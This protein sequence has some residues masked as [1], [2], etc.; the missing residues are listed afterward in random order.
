MPVICP[1]CN[2]DISCVSCND[3][4]CPNCGED[5]PRSIVM[6]QAMACS[7]RAPQEQKA[8]DRPPLKPIMVIDG[9]LADLPP[10]ERQEY[11]DK[12]HNRY[13]VD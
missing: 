8:A 5:I 12:I 13:Q 10:K 9:S 6:N 7:I 4:V 3:Y 11:L 1:Y 2:K